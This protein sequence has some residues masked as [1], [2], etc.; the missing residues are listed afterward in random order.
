MVNLKTVS[1]N[2]KRHITLDT[3]DYLRSL[4]ATRWTHATSPFRVIAARPVLIV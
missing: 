3:S 4:H 1:V 2:T